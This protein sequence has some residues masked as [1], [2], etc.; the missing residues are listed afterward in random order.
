[1]TPFQALYRHLPP[2]ITHYHIGMSLINEVDQQLTTRDELL[3]LLKANLHAAS[4][5][6]Q[7]LGNSKRRDIEFQEG[8]W[9][10]LNLH[11]YHQQSVVKR[12]CKKL[13]SRVAYEF[14]LPVEARIHPVFHV[15]L[16]KKKVGDEPLTTVKLPPMADNGEMRKEVVLEEKKSG[17][18]VLDSMWG[19]CVLARNSNCSSPYY[20][21]VRELMVGESF[22]QPTHGWDK[23]VE[24][25]AD[26]FIQALVGRKGNGDS[27]AT[28]N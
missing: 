11:A 16:L 22:L 2:T 7:Q 18:R 26:S 10:F 17:L 24:P 23:G 8:E 27:F 1:M 19:V 3:N 14:K 28:V 21:A 9:F 13:A 20:L 6:M 12:A 15:S 4:N 5:R 25:A